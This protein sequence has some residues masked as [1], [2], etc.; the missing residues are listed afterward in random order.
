MNQA[1]AERIESGLSCDYGSDYEE[2]LEDIDEDP[3][4]DYREDEYFED[5]EEEGDFEDD[6]YYD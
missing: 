5:E 2:E 4:D 1:E 6:E 3:E